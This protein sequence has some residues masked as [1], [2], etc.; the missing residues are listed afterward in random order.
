MLEETVRKGTLRNAGY[1]ITRHPL[2]SWACKLLRCWCSVHTPEK[3]Q[4]SI[5]VCSEHCT[6]GSEEEADGEGVLREAQTR[7][8]E[9]FAHTAAPVPSGEP[10]S[11]QETLRLSPTCALCHHLQQPSLPP[12]WP[13]F[14]LQNK[15]TSALSQKEITLYKL[16]YINR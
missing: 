9:E 7:G 4:S 2:C 15:T 8:L 14:L 6:H 12:L 1:Y 5:P 10:A 11:V 3:T 16:A 13:T